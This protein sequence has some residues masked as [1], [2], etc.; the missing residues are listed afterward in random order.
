MQSQ[1]QDINITDVLV[2]FRVFFLIPDPNLLC[3][4]FNI[5]VALVGGPGVTL[6]VLSL[7][8]FPIVEAPSRSMV[9]INVQV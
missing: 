3:T 7:K 6:E 2:V 1:A 8:M 4:L 5:D 9:E